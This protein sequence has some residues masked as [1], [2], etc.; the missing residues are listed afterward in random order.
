MHTHTYSGK[1]HMPM[2]THAY[3]LTRGGAKR[4]VENWDVCN[5]GAIDGQWRQLANDNIFTWRKAHPTSYKDV[6][7]GTTFE[8]TLIHTYI[9]PYSYICSYS[10][11][12]IKTYIHTF[13]CLYGIY[14]RV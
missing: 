10:Y 11:T 5:P 6:K 3:L 14:N 4:M 9:P 12:Y 7:P 13:M 2:C 1:R 8:Y